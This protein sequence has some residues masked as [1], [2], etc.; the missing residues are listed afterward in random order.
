MASNNDSKRTR[1]NLK[2][3]TCSHSGECSNNAIRYPLPTNRHHSLSIPYQSLLVPNLSLLVATLQW[4]KSPGPPPT[5]PDCDRDDHMILPFVHSAT[6]P[7]VHSL[8]ATLPFV[9]VPFVLPWSLVHIYIPPCSSYQSN[10]FP[11]PLL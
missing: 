5:R 8:M 2:P 6:W 3:V 10:Q 4:P 7:L 1:R 11:S 9:L